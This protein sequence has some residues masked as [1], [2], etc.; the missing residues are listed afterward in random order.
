MDIVAAVVSLLFFAVVMAA[1]G[2]W[3][4]SRPSYRRRCR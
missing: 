2:R 3:M 1:V 4:Q